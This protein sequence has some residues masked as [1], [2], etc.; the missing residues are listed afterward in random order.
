MPS[1]LK[2][3][4]VFC[5]PFLLHATI[6][7]GGS[8]TVVGAY[9]NHGSIGASFETRSSEVGS[10]GNHSG[11]IEVLYAPVTHAIVD[12][13]VDG[14]DDRWEADNSLTVGVDDSFSDE[15]G[16]GVSA[17]MEFLA[18]SDPNDANSFFKPIFTQQGGIYSLT[19]QS[20]LNRHY[21]F[22][23]SADLET[24]VDWTDKT[25]TGE[26]ITFTF[27]P[28]SEDAL[29]EFTAEELVKC[30]FRIELSFTQ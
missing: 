27:E 23:V 11:L 9:H 10:D 17:L 14:M 30:F 16:D 15:D 1:I 29:S 26:L 5:L 21:R 22:W 13:D 20:Q 6:D 7:S 12:V 8:Q 4:S 24:W 2:V 3:L 18:G 25:G 28:S 19:L